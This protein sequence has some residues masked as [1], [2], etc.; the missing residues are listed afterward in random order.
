MKQT[1]NSMEKST[2][3]SKR[4]VET[5]HC[6]YI[7]LYS[8]WKKTHIDFTEKCAIDNNGCRCTN[9]I[10]A[11]FDKNACKCMQAELIF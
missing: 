1:E 10:L 7:K 3:N 4:Y 5:K 2:Q 9:A 11:I 8:I 6:Y